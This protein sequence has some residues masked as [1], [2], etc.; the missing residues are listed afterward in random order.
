MKI[1]LN[2]ISKSFG[3][4]NVLKS[5]SFIVESGSVH[6]LMGEN[7]A[8]KSTL[9]KIIGGVHKLDAGEILIN[10]LPAEIHCIKDSMSHGIAYVHQELNVVQALTVLENMFLGAEIKKRSGFLDY[11]SMRKKVDLV[12]KSLN[13]NISPDSLMGELSVGKQQMIE[14]AKS[15][16]FKAKLIILDEPTAALSDKE[17]NTLFIVIKDLQ[18][19]GVSFIYVSHRMNE[20][21][22]IS[23][24]ISVIRDGK[25]VGT[26]DTNDCSEDRLIKMMIGKSLQSLFPEYQDYKKN[27]AFKVKSLTSN[28][29]FKNINFSLCYGEVLGFS[30]LMGAGRSELMHSL[31]GSTTYDSGEIF[32]NEKSVLI[33]NPIDAAKHGIGFVTED[34]KNEGLI[35]QDSIGKNITLPSLKKYVRNFFVDNSDIINVSNTKIKELNIKCASEKQSVSDLSGGN[36][37]KVVLAKW[38]EIN[39]KVLILDEPTRGVDIGA[40]KEIYEIINQLKKAGTAI[41]VVSSELTEVIGVSDRVAVMRNGVIEGIL[42]RDEVTKEKVLKLAFTGAAI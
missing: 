1:Q 35:L 41:I 12:F 28:G 24:Q 40:K 2:E 11:H 30:G 34:R 37:Q 33:K 7:G 25:Y 29:L 3:P 10:G 5:I 26:V 27:E 4:V 16:L 13:L 20:I 42:G 39:P 36:Q 15:L 9:I 38:L 6:A 14:I 22:E 17:I 31:F 19:Q 32:V 23:N 8:G 18:S 21:F